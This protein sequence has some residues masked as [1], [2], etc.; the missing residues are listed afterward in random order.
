MQSLCRIP[1][2]LLLVCVPIACGQDVGSGAPNGS[3]TLGFLSSYYRNNFSNLVVLPPINNVTKL[4]TTGYVQEFNSAAGTA[5]GKYALILPNSTGA[6]S[7][8]GAYA[9]L[10]SLP[11]LYGYYT[12]VGVT[13]AG[14]PVNDTQ[15]CPNLAGNSCWYQFF[16]KNYVLFSYAAAVNGSANYFTRDPYYTKWQA[17]GGIFG[18]GPAV[19]AETAFTS[20]AGAVSTVQV[21]NTGMVVNIT[22]GTQSARIVGVKEPIYGLYASKGGY[23]GAMGLPLTD[24]LKQS[25]GHIRQTFEAGTVDYDPANPSN[26]TFLLP[27]KALILVPTPLSGTL[28]MN[29]GDTATLTATAYGTDGGALTGRT[30]TWST[31][32][33]RIVSIQANGNTATLKAVG[34]GTANIT[35]SAEG[36]TSSA[37]NVFVTAPCCAVGEGS[38]TPALQQSFQ[39]AITRNKLNP[40]LPAASPVIRIGAGYIQQLQTADTGDTFWLAAAQST[41]SAYL[42]KGALLVEYQNQGAASSKLGYPISDPTA[43]GRQTFEGGA[44]AGSPVQLVTGA[45]LSKWQVLGFDTGAAGSPTAAA[46]PFLSVQATS[47]VS[48]SFKNATLFAL[49]SG[50]QAGKVYSV[51]GPIL[52]VYGG[53]GSTLGVPVNDEFGLNGLRHQDFEGGYVE[54]TPGDTAGR[55]V[56]APRVPTVT[57]TPNSAPAGSVVRLSLGGFDPGAQ[58]RVSITG[59]Q[60]FLAAVPSGSYIWENYIPATATSSSVTIKAVDVKSQVSSQAS[61]SIRGGN[62]ARLTLKAVAGDTQTGLPGATLP[63]R[64]QVRFADDGGNPIPNATVRFVPSPG[65][66]IGAD[67]SLVTDASG[68]ASTSWRLPSQEGVAL[69]AV[70]VSGKLL[71]ISARATHSGLANFPVLS[72]T[73]IGTALGNGTDPISAKGGLL[74]SAAAAIRYYQNRGEMPTPQGAADPVGLNAYLKSA[75]V[76][77]STGTQNCDGFLQP[78][79]ASDQVVNLW[80]LRDFVNKALDIRTI[81][82]DDRFVRDALAVGAP[83]ILALNLTMNGSSAGSHFVVATGVDASGNLSIMDPKY[84]QTSFYGY[85]YGFQVGG[86]TLAATMTGAA[87]VTAQTPANP[88]FL[89]G[90]SAPT[91]VQ[92]PAGLCGGGFVFPVTSGVFALHYCDGTA[93]FYELDMQPGDSPANFQGSFI[94]L[95]PAAGRADFSGGGA[96]SFAIDHSSGQ[97]TLAPLAVQFLSSGVINS[98]SLTTDLAPGGLASI[99]GMGLASPGALPVVA[100]NGEYTPV[101][102]ATP[103]QLDI[104]IPPSATVGTAMIDVVSD[105]SGS[106]EQTVTLKPYAPAI[107]LVN[108]VAR[109]GRL[110]NQDGS[111]NSRYKPATRGQMVNIFGTGFGALSI[112]VQVFI[113]GVEVPGST[114][115]AVP[116]SPGLYQ[117]KVMIPVGLTPGL[118]LDLTLLQGEAKSNSVDLAVQ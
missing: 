99:T 105:L 58:I 25:N 56:P 72:Q 81:V 9:V 55:V 40:K 49:T 51:G 104:Q 107:Q 73:G 18:M 85:L 20:G 6:A 44:L 38:P 90:V 2:S 27:V 91:S 26:I 4:G 62:D 60:D 114:V 82:P 108:G 28:R 115:A 110:T 7:G 11:P 43:A 112:P 50:L 101:L 12:Q 64:I 39:D 79:G 92:A 83:V 71:N 47:G 70:N 23:S 109:R 76:T 100:V 68:L 77:D 78:A 52:A 69:L 17:V 111:A 33:G 5:G 103:F 10:Q 57:A 106:A 87:A 66:E 88:G 97:W 35:V 67:A 102:K 65:G 84:G 16:T 95:G 93:I 31:T 59:Q 22:G 8:D 94:D 45:I 96:A 48:Q 21:Y 89:I 63:A 113:G 32:N 3:I 80:R 34:G 41:G 74:V 30:F 14:Y 29:E 1:L 37:V 117:V 116:N 46:A 54:Y 42:L 53:P 75:C 61:Y 15:A 13:T 36:I 118:G 19:G 24:E 86:A 98:A